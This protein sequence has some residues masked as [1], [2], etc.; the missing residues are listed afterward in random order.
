[1]SEFILELK[2]ITKVFPGVRAL[3]KVT[4]CDRRRK[5]RGEIYIYKDNNRGSEADR[6]NRNI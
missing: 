6:R 1:M 4:S 5:R 3:D 2:N